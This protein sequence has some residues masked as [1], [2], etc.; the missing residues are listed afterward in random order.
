[1]S[2]SFPT[3][4]WSFITQLRES[5]GKSR[6]VLIESF[7]VRYI[8]PMRSYLDF[9]F[10]LISEHDR[11]DMLQDF[12]ADR[13]IQ[14]SILDQAQKEQGRLRAF[15]QTCLMNFSRSWLT[16][17]TKH[18]AE[19]FVEIE[20]DAWMQDTS[21]GA[22][23]HFDVVWARHVLSEAI[24]RLKDECY[25]SGKQLMWDVF[26][27]RMLRPMLT[28][29]DEVAYD[30]LAERLGVDQKK[31][32]NLLTTAKRKLKRH[33][34]DIVGDYTSNVD[35]TELEIQQLISILSEVKR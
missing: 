9:R 13:L 22:W 4:H 33:L 8:A 12:L 32:E 3:T 23:C 7:L 29:A 2:A 28:G 26:D 14:K 15:L 20:G 24:I 5:D 35:E 34:L 30:D 16:R 6:R 19:S 31:M 25:Q 18:A 10:K 11:E 27:L 17:H 21:Q 1:M